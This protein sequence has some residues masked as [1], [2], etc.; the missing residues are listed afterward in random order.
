MAFSVAVLTVSDTAASQPETDRSGPLLVEAF[1]QHPSRSF[2]L[3][4]SAIV[5]DDEHAIRQA[6]Q[7]W[8]DQEAVRLVITTGG[9]GFGLRDRTPEALAP[10]IT[11][12]TPAL[13]HAITA[14]S[15]QKTPLAALSRSVTGIRK[16]LR[17]DSHHES[18]IVALPGSPK[19]VSECLEVLLGCQE[20]RRQGQGV[21]LHALELLGG[22]SG[23]GQHQKMQGSAARSAALALPAADTVST[24]TDTGHARSLHSGHHHGH[25]HHHHHAN[26][27]HGHGCSHHLHGGQGLHSHSAPVPRTRP[28]DHQGYF[29]FKTQDPASGPSLRHRQSPYP[30][31]HLDEALRLIA[32]HT[33][34][35]SDLPDGGTEMRAVDSSLVGHVL[36]EDVVASRDLPLGPTTNVDGYAVKASATPIGDYRVATLRTLAARDGEG[37]RSGEIF[38]INTGQGLPAGTDAVVMVEDTE[39]IEVHPDEGGDE[40]LGGEEKKVR[41]LA[42]VDAGENVRQKASDVS[43]GTVVL[44]Q[45]TLLSG[46]GGEVG[47]LAFV[48]RRE[49][50]VYRK[51]KVAILSTGNEL[52]DIRHADDTAQQQAW[53]FTVYDA[54]RPGLAAALRGM[55]YECIDLGIVGDE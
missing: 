24:A 36:A 6:V 13:T 37:L 41:V 14:Y 30:I 49:V 46:L 17:P 40:G 34:S 1:E 47:T 38:R 31:I 53:G 10:L 27:G 39:L 15:L 54:N 2:S 28:E 26:N 5:A 21:L 45:G 51:P 19:A 50:R 8:I 43:E 42:Q 52:A 9:T 16:P 3:H 11:R 55:G 25:H 20:Q 35:P 29:P 22:G 44:R 12:N 7:R 4:Q 32:E 33:P 48:G 23:Q 18:L